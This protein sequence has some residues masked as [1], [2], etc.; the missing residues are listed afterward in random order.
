[1]KEYSTVQL[2]KKLG[3]AR[4]T[5]YRWIRSKRIE[6]GR[7]HRFGTGVQVR[8]WTEKDLKAIGRW[9]KANPYK[10]RGIKIKKK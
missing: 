4:D 9:M 5:I 8:I 6:G 7:V 3:I 1:V 10:S 2:A